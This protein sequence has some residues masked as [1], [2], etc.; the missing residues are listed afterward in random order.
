MIIFK[1]LGS[2]DITTDPCDLPDEGMQRC[3]NLRLDENGVLKIRDGSY[4]LNS[5]ALS[6]TMDFI[7]EQGGNRYILGGKY[8]YKNESLIATGIQC[9]DPAF[10]PAAGEYAAAQS[11]EI[12]SDTVGA[13]IYYTLDGTTPSEASLKYVSAISVPLYTTVKAVAVRDG[14]LDSDIT[15]GYYSSTTPGTLVTETDASTVITETDDNT[16]VTEGAP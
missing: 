15:V 11:V 2:L 10:S 13:T 5:T 1:P 14:F 6:G 12:T 4:K 9:S 3:K 16:L 8:I 7:I